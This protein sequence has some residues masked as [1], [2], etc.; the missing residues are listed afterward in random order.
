MVAPWFGRCARILRTLRESLSSS[1]WLR[2]DHVHKIGECSHSALSSSHRCT[3][4]LY[5]SHAQSFTMRNL[6]CHDHFL[7]H[8]AMSPCAFKIRCPGSTA[9]ASMKWTC[10]PD[11]HEVTCVSARR[12]QR[13]TPLRSHTKPSAAELSL[14]KT[15]V[16]AEPLHILLQGSRVAIPSLAPPLSA[17]ISDS[18][19]HKQTMFFFFLEDSSQ[20]APFPWCR[21][22]P[23][24]AFLD[25]FDDP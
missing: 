24:Q 10:V 16:E 21:P 5:W 19:E 23:I 12:V 8:S 20:D 7:K 4:I 9:Q 11:L 15:I 25:K 14:H 22:S 3:P 1:E 2:T 17:I 13:P 18:L 6:R